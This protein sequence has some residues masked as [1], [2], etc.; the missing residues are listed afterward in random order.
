MVDKRRGGAERRRER[1]LR[2]GKEGEEEGRRQEKIDGR[3]GR[4]KDER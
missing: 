3:R 1:G 4:G 2:R